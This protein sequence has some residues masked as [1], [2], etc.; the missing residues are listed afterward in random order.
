M[1][2][3]KCSQDDAKAKGL[4]AYCQELFKDSKQF[5]FWSATD[6]KHNCNKL[7]NQ[8]VNSSQKDECALLNEHMYGQYHEE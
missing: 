1:N 2:Y 3:D 5:Y 7:K 4:P 8:K 6:L